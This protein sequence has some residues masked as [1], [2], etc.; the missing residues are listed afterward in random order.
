MVHYIMQKKGLPAQLPQHLVTGSR[1]LQ[2]VPRQLMPKETSCVECAGHLSEPMLITANAKL[3]TYTGVVDGFSTYC[4]VCSDCG[5]MYRYQEWSDGIH[6]F[7]DHILITLHLCIILRTSLQT[8]HSVS[9]AIEVL[10]QTENKTFPKKATIL[11]AYMHFEALTSHNYSYS[12]FKCGYYPPV[13]VMDLH[14]KDVFNM[15][16]GRKNPFVVGPSYNYWAPWI[17]P[18]TRKGDTVLNTEHEKIHALRQ[19]TEMADLQVTE[20]RLQDALINLRVDMV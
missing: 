9:R 7:N 17:G 19:A 12:C 4:R 3:V 20:E 14:R 11:H 13:V 18:K 15:P 16:G 8:H 2:D 5:L 10:E 1:S 6:N